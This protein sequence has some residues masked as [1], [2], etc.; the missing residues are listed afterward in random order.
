MTG[1]A[2][3]AQGSHRDILHNNIIRFSSVKSNVHGGFNPST[4]KFTCNDESLYLFYATIASYN[5]GGYGPVWFQIVQDGH[6]RAAGYTGDAKGSVGT[7]FAMI[8]CR[9]GSQVWV[10]QGHVNS[11]QGMWE[12]HSQFGGFHIQI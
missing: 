12:G 1:R 4:S 3:H 9:P 2:F 5:G 8:R 6:V 10:K 7:H 11:K